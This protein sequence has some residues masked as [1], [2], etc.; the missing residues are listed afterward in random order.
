MFSISWKCKSSFD[1]FTCFIIDLVIFLLCC[2]YLYCRKRLY[3]VLLSMICNTRLKS[4]CLMCLL[5]V[6]TNVFKLPSSFVSAFW[7]RNYCCHK[8][9]LSCLIDTGVILKP[10]D[11]ICNGIVYAF[12]ID[13]LGLC[14]SSSNLNWYIQY[15]L[16]LEHLVWDILFVVSKLL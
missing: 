10:S 1:V 2:C 16:S 5:L 9:A 6:C 13:N 11:Y 14:F 12:D 4:S 8:V 15:R 7:V 3:F